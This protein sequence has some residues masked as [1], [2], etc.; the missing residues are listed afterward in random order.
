MTIYCS[1]PH[2]ILFWLLQ[3]VLVSTLTVSCPFLISFNYVQIVALAAFVIGTFKITIISFIHSQ[4]IRIL[5]LRNLDSVENM[6]LF[7]E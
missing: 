1:K 6:E 4:R 5:I 7:S 3:F 2:K